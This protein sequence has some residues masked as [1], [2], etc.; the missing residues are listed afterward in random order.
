MCIHTDSWGLIALGHQNFPDFIKVTVHTQYN[1][2][3][4]MGQQLII[5][6]INISASKHMNIQLSEI[7]KTLNSLMSFQVR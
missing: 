5:K 7:I 6:C 4:E 3:S 2:P 1:I